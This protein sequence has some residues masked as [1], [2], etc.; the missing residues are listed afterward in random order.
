MHNMY[1]HGCHPSLCATYVLIEETV[2]IDSHILIVG[3]GLL[4][5]FLFLLLCIF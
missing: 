1:M 3:G 4:G 5:D 2:W